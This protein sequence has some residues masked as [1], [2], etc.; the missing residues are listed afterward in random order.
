MSLQV[1]TLGPQ[2]L[3][4]VSPSGKTPMIVGIIKRVKDELKATSFAI[5]KKGDVCVNTK[6]V[7]HE[8]SA[9]LIP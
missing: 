5:V 4:K 9:V 3:S 2:P 7:V 8:I 1:G 6:F